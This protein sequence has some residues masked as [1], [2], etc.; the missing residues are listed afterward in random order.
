VVYWFDSNKSQK[1]L[2]LKSMQ[3]SVSLIVQNKT[4]S[5]CFALLDV[6]ELFLTKSYSSLLWFSIK[7]VR[8][9]LLCTSPEI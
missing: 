9:I 7:F 1:I 3:E 5:V 6:S 4:G 2:Q 8:A